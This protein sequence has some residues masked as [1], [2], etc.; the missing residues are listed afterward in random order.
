MEHATAYLL[1]PFRYFLHFYG[2]L[3]QC[4]EQLEAKWGGSGATTPA[5]SSSSSSRL[6]VDD[7]P[8]ALRQLRCLVKFVEERILP[9]RDGY[10]H[11]GPA[12]GLK[13][14]IRFDDLFYLFKPGELAFRPSRD[15]PDNYRQSS[16]TQSAWR[17]VGVRC[18]LPRYTYQTVNSARSAP[19]SLMMAGSSDWDQCFVVECYYIDFDGDEYCPVTKLFP[20]Q[21]FDNER[22]VKQLPI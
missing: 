15:D 14:K 8:D 6:S 4:L 13:Q 10:L 11:P 9:L 22:L 5:D 17:V 12:G 2:D 19:G 21:P 18:P 7:S 1:S 20:I 16:I 3:R